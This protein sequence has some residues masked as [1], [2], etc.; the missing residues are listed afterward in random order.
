MLS[1]M[2]IRMTPQRNKGLMKWRRR[3]QRKKAEPRKRR[4]GMRIAVSGDWATCP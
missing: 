3:I 2:T 4:I 1:L